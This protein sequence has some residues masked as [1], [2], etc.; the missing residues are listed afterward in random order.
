MD[1]GV[2]F[3]MDSGARFTMGS[4]ARFTMGSGARFTMDSGARSA[5][6]RTNGA[7]RYALISERTEVVKVN[8]SGLTHEQRG[9][10]RTVSACPL[11]SE[12][13]ADGA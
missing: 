6:G 11:P 2:R 8:Y 1:S 5:M 3:T 4:G 9:G 10:T 7:F 13:I 12:A